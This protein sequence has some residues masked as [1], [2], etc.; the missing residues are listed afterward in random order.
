VYRYGIV[1]AGKVSIFERGPSGPE[2]LKM[3]RLRTD[4]LDVLIEDV[5]EPPVRGLSEEADLNVLPE[6][7][8]QKKRGITTE[9]EFEK[10]LQTLMRNVKGIHLVCFHLPITVKRV[11]GAGGKRFEV[12]WAESLMAKSEGSVA[13]SALIVRWFGTLNIPGD[14]VTESEKK[15]LTGTS[16]FSFLCIH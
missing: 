4:M 16:F 3:R 9:E 14:P 6:L 2:D 10:S 11:S 8:Y 13:N 7:T 1:E 5:F 15:E 12:T